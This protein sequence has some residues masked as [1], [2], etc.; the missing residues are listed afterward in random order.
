[1]YLTLLH[2]HL[3]FRCECLSLYITKSRKYK[4]NTYLLRLKNDIYF[5]KNAYS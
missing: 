2:V 3:I 1:M 4:F 5:A